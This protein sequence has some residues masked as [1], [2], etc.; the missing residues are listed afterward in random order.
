VVQSIND[1]HELLERYRRMFDKNPTQLDGIAS[2]LIEEIDYE[3]EI[4]KQ[5][6]N[7]DQQLARTAVIDQF[8]DSMR[9]YLK[10]ADEPSLAGFLEESALFGREEESDKEEQLESEGIRLMTL[11]SAKG[12]EFPHVYL[13]G[14]EEGLLPHQR[15]VEMEGD[16]IEEERRLAYVGVTRAMQTL[17]ITRAAGRMKWGKR[18]P[19]LPSRFLHEML[20]DAADDELSEISD[21]VSAGDA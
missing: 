1:F 16:A 19:S 9:E 15:S 5:Y 3:S 7:A 11:H 12:L 8:L 18:R 20:G 2:R 21:P 17:T 14:L 6:S 4:E 13:V 10:R